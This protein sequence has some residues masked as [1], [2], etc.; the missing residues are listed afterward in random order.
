MIELAC[1]ESCTYLVEARTSASQ[2]EMALRQKE[3]ADAPGNMLLNERA[4]IALDGIERAIVNSQRGIGATSF[5]DLDDA[6]ILAA[7]ENTIKNLETEE[8]GLI[9]EHR[10][11]SPRI[12]ELSRR[13]RERL[14]EVG[15]DAPLE[16]RPRRSDVLKALTF[17]RDAVEAHIKRAA[18]DPEASRSFMRYISLFSPW[19]ADATTPL[20]I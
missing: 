15:N 20:I 4:M 14:D 1:P 10:A 11:E 19:P 16:V 2:R 6:E 9:Y 7:L 17:M 5:R 18:G 13:I 8:S 3:T 12:G